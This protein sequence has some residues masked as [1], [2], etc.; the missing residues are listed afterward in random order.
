[1]GGDFAGFVALDDVLRVVFRRRDL[2]GFDLS[3]RRL[4][5]HYFADTMPTRRIPRYFVTTLQGLWHC[6]LLLRGTDRFTG[7][8]RLPLGFVPDANSQRTARTRESVPEAQS[9]SDPS[10]RMY[11]TCP[12]SGGELS[13]SLRMPSRVLRCCLAGLV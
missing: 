11:R 12:S 6:R 4:L 1:M 9:T 13:C 2:L 5:L 8:E 7:R 3:R 10:D